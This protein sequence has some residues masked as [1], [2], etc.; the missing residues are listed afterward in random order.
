MYFFR[1][2]HGKGLG[3]YRFH[4]YTGYCSHKMS[5]KSLKCIP[6]FYSWWTNRHLL[7]THYSYKERFKW[8]VRRRRRCCCRSSVPIRF[9][10]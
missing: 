1:N 3:Y 9:P 8:C 2:T 10:R 6:H 4:H 7:F 5:K